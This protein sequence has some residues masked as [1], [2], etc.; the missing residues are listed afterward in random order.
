MLDNFKKVDIS[1]IILMW[2]VFRATDLAA[3]LVQAP[4]SFLLALVG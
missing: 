1:M 4:A 2:L 3:H